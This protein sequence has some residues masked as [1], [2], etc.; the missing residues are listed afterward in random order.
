MPPFSTLSI[1]FECP[2]LPWAS[3]LMPLHDH[4]TVCR[5][6]YLPLFLLPL[7]CLPLS[8]PHT[9]DNL[10][11]L[12]YLLYMR[13]ATPRISFLF[14]DWQE[15][16]A[17]KFQIGPTLRGESCSAMG[18]AI[19]FCLL[20]LQ[21]LHP[22]CALVTLVL[23]LSSQEPNLGLLHLCTEASVAL[24]VL[25]NITI[26][27][28]FTTIIYSTCLPLY[29]KSPPVHSSSSLSWADNGTPTPDSR[30]L[31]ALSPGPVEQWAGTRCVSVQGRIF[32][33][34]LLSQTL[35]EYQFRGVG[36]CWWLVTL[37][38]WQ[39]SRDPSLLQEPATKIIAGLTNVLLWASSVWY[40]KNGINDTASV[41]GLC[42]ALQAWAVTK[43]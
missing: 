17:P 9:R 33:H 37:L 32:G 7:L 3:S 16:G 5:R 18:I 14:L 38:H 25:C 40:A 19:D 12:A 23:E 26:F 35:T 42:A 21:C 31:K 8:L 4:P 41:V 6:R 34:E 1:R 27:L 11:V 29:C 30:P 36:S 22:A 13:R 20:P 43:A 2:I 24:N 39:W 28:Y 10:F 15:F